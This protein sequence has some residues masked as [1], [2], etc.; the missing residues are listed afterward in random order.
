MVESS[1]LKESNIA[2][3]EEETNSVSQDLPPQT[4]QDALQ[5]EEKKPGKVFVIQVG[6][7]RKKSRASLLAEKLK[8]EGYEAYIV[9]K[10]LKDKGIWYRVLVGDFLNKEEAKSVLDKLKKKYP[11]SFIVYRKAAQE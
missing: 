8:R 1:L 3:N 2:L 11:Q 6:S 7:F 4:H 5:Q 10:D 9:K